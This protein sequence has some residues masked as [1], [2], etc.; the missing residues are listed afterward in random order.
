MFCVP[1]ITSST[2]EAIRKMSV[3]AKLADVLEVRLDLMDSFDIQRIVKAAEKPVLVTYRSVGEG[4]KG[5]D[6]PELVANHLI[7]GIEAG[8][9]FV[10]VELSMFQ[11]ARKRIINARGKSKIVVSTHVHTGTPS[12]PELEKLFD[13]SIE[14]GA[15][16]VKIVTMAHEWE[17]NLRILELVNRAKKAGVKIISFCMGPLGRM[18]RVFSVPMGAYMTFASLE[19]GQESANG[20]IPVNKMKEIMEFFTT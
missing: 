2:E 5:K 1:I 14:A 4:G 17:D 15:D 20:Q 7:A 10:D 3:A 18:S 19:A 9:G 13:M 12:S 8:A 16:I 6:S 11:D